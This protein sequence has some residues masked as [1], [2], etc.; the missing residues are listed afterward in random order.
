MSM[1]KVIKVLFVDDD[2][3]TRNLYTEALRS[4]NFDVRE[5]NDGL[6]GLKLA[7]EFRPDIIVSG[8]IMPRMD[9]FGFVEALAKNVTTAHI[10][11]IFF[12]HLGREEDRERAATLGVKDFLLR[13]MTTPN[14]V[15]QR[16][17]DVLTAKE[18]ILGIDPFNF[19]AAKFALDLNINPDFI[20]PEE[21]QGG[22]VVLKLRK[23]DGHAKQFDAE[24]TCV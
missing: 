10:P 2:V 9:G 19:D 5:G 14:D 18:Y 22:R 8:I 13:D 12:S 16:I 24:L 4:V 17:N 21:K 1:D 15:I 3:D 20:C 6:D 7:D 11:V 23:K